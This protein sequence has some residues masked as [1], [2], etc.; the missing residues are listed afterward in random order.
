VRLASGVNLNMRGEHRNR[1]AA[2]V[3]SGVDV[4][5]AERERAVAA[6]AARQRGV[7]TRAQLLRVGWTGN[8]IDYRLRS[9]RLHAL[10]RGI[11]LVGHAVAPRGARELAAV[12][13]CGPGAV[14][15]HRTAARLWR[16][17]PG[18][19]H[20]LDVTVAGRDPGLKPG[21]RIHCVAALAHR[22]LRKLGGIPITAPARTLLDLAAVV[23][24]RELERAL[25]EAH[26][27]RLARRNELVALL[28]R[29]PRRPGV[30]ALRALLD[31]DGSPSL[32]RSEAEER[33]LALVR[34]AD[35]P[36]PETNVRLGAHEVDFLWREQGLI[37]EVDGFAFHSSRP[38]FERDRLRDA[39]LGAQGFRVI[40]I[41]WRQL[42]DRPEAVIARIASALRG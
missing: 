23:S 6:L 33:L 11:Y 19:E 10:R 34:A 38:A 1:S 3:G 39:Q 36:A 14:L 27:R 20:E 26:S 22:E 40:R 25:A 15:S 8:A 28:A 5:H 16:L 7:V 37:V 29:Y 30:A 13:A 41:T 32:T 4:G 31:S 17:L 35:L 42:V 24:A 12:L 2:G 18:T 21:I 9:G